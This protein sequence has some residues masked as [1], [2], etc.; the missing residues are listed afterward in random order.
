MTCNTQSTGEQ[1]RPG[2]Q[3][4]RWCLSQGEHSTRVSAYYWK[5][6]GARSSTFSVT[7]IFLRAREDS[8][9]HPDRSMPPQFCLRC[10]LIFTSQLDN[11]AS[12]ANLGERMGAHRV[13]P[14]QL[15]LTL[16]VW[17]LPTQPSQLPAVW[18]LNFLC[19]WN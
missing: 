11:P 1:E 8:F 14:G 17:L 7:V 3:S 12:L 6:C 2:G 19:D 9:P 15:S 13:L 5:I 10:N 16:V 4:G 18:E